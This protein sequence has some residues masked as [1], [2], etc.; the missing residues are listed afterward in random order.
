MSLI[1]KEIVDFKVQAFVD[2]EFREITKADVLGKWSVFFFY[3]ADFTFVC[4]TELEDLADKYADFKNIDWFIG[5]DFN[6]SSEFII[7]ILFMIFS[8]S[9][10]YFYR[11]LSGSIIKLK[12]TQEKTSLTLSVSKQSLSDVSIPS[13]GWK[14]IL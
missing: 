3:P 1:N 8:F 7:S 2:G 12:P 6:S 14:D 13:V 5:K 10:S 9:V 4:P 11:A